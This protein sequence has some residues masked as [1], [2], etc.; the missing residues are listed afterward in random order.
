MPSLSCDQSLYRRRPIQLFPRR[1]LLL[2]YYRT[3][4]TRWFSASTA[5]S[6]RTEFTEE[7]AY[8]LLG[9]SE[10][11]SFAEIK[12][13]FHKLA[14][15]THPDLVQSGNDSDVSRRFVQI[16]AAY[17]ILSDCERR[18]H[19]DRDL[20]SQRKLM[21]KQ[22]GGGGALHL[23]KFHSTY[24]GMEVVEWLKWYRIAISDVLA[25]RK[26]VVGTGY[27]D[28]LERDFYSAIHAAFYGPDI[29]SIDFLPDCFEAEE[30]SVYETPEVLHLVSGRDVFGMVCLVDKIPELPYYSNKRLKYSTSAGLGIC[31]SGEDLRISMSSGGVYND[32]YAH[33][34]AADVSTHTSDPYRDLELHISGRVVATA[35]RVPPKS[36]CDR[37]QNED[38]DHIHVFLSSDDNPVHTSKGFTEASSSGSAVGSRIL[39][40]T[41]TGLRSS[42]EEG[43]CLVYNSSGTKTHVIMKHRTLLV[44]HMHWYGLGDN[45]SVCECRCTRARLPP[46]KFWL[47][48]PRCGMHDIGGWYVETFGKDK[49]GRLSP[50]QRYWDGFDAREQSE[51]RLH[52]AMY[53]L[54][55]GYRTLDLE[56]AKRRKHTFRD[57]V[58]RKLFKILNWC[59]RRV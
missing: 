32:G 24:R 38:T 26:V 19:Y 11:S 30:R 1:Y 2:F 7:N 58:D 54:A 16:L 3:A 33:M 56:D 43:S 42:S 10:T 15:Q 47:F 52:P 55:M 23:Y 51:K 53:L 25:E 12:A 37:I 41:I 59:K 46:S 29:E 17:E 28:G 50:S 39:L 6:T 40:G 35:T 4:G 48:E 18:A 27:F 49:K 44:K 34:Q 45:V 20:L 14:K 9:V 8:E 57:V 31:Q 13:S 5:E 36:C 21:Q 22:S